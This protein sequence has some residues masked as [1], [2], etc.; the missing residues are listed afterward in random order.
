MST[1]RTVL[2]FF[3]VE[4]VGSPIKVGGGR[5][6]LPKLFDLL[7]FTEGAE[8][9][10]RKGSFSKDLVAANPKLHLLCVDPWCPSPDYQ[11]PTNNLRSMRDAYKIAK[12]A[13]RP[14]DVTLFKGTSHDAVSRVKDR[15]LDFVY[16]D[17]NHLEPFV[18]DDLHSWE[19]KVRRGGIL[20]GHDYGFS[21]QPFIQ[22]KSAVD[23]YVEHNAI[24]PWFV[25]TG[26]KS[27]S[28]FW[29]VQ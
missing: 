5:I 3:G 29:V 11:E 18:T 8:I 22:V 28:F 16:I 10:V 15:S 1:L 6:Q 7:G 2:D 13:L 20:A 4:P 27:H 12:E 17:G 21:K 26:D 14:Y 25:L 9:G 24:D 23:K 19:P